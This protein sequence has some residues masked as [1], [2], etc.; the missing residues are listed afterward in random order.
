M[1]RQHLAGE[2]Q[3]IGAKINLSAGDLVG[4]LNCH[5]LTNLDLKVANGE[6]VKPKIWDPV[7]EALAARGAEHE[8]GYIDH[9]KSGGLRSRGSTELVSTVRQW[10]PRVKQWLGAMQ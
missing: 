2:M 10:Q 7:L 3:K 5:Y 6:L 1:Q 8:Q 4:H 9:L